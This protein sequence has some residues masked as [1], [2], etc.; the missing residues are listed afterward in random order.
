MIIVGELINGTRAAVRAALD[1]RDADAIADLARRQVE[2]G[3]DYLDCNVGAVGAS[4]VELMGWL[5]RTVGQAVDAPVCIDT[6]SPAAMAAGL[7]EYRGDAPPLVN[8]V[9]LEGA[10]L[11]ETLAVLGGRRVRIVALAM[12]DAG[13]PETGHGRAQASLRLIGELTDRGLAAVDIFVDPV[14]TPLSV[15]GAG[16]RAACEAMRAIASARPECHLICGISNVSFGLPERALLNRVFLAQ[17]VAAGLDSAILDPIDRPL[18]ATLHAAE[19]LAGGDAW[20]AGYLQAYR[21][22][23][24]REAA[25]APH[26]TDP[27]QRSH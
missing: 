22:G 17:A 13:V 5:V 4:E 16:A 11:E 21:R 1:R 6:P 27:A 2:A 12:T 25:Y 8:S 18:R 20:C 14:V 26:G 24:L 15:D 10:R 23:L 3:A 9:T 19:A 7:S